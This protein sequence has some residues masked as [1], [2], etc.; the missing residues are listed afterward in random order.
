MFRL[1][2]IGFGE[3]FHISRLNQIFK[4]DAMAVLYVNFNSIDIGKDVDILIA[5]DSQ[6]K[7]NTNRRD[8]SER[9]RERVR[10]Q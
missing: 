6:R 3:V 7:R 1:K 10:D 2:W 9:E 8:T 4:V 5:F